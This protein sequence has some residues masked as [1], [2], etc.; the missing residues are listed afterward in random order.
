MP[1]LRINAFLSQMNRTDIFA[2]WSK[3][4]WSFI[5]A[6]FV[7]SMYTLGFAK[8]FPLQLVRASDGTEDS[9]SL[10]LRE[11]LKKL[12]H[13]FVHGAKST[14]KPPLSP[15]EA[16][17]IIG[18][19]ERRVDVNHGA[20][21]YFETNH[22]A[23]NNPLEDRNSENLL[24]KTNGALF[25]VFDGHGGWQCAEAVHNRLPLY[26]ALTLLPKTELKCVEKNI[27]K[28]LHAADFVESFGREENVSSTPQ[29]ARVAV[30]YSLSQKQE[31]FH[32]GPKYL[33]KNLSQ[34]LQTERLPIDEGLRLAF[35]QLDDDISTEAIPVKVLDDSFMAGA[36]GS[37]AVVSYIEGQHLYVANSGKLGIIE[38]TLNISAC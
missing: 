28:K 35:T 38:N 32:T 15:K 22:L 10:G 37:C 24:L 27:A 5:G 11:L 1:S 19:N 26:V 29:A 16:S 31:V 33:V 6:A 13:G 36:S 4:K 20:I 9:S 7:G 25:G 8:K 30:G 34:N 23:S 18:Q 17:D 21:S 2:S 3:W 14:D 12:I